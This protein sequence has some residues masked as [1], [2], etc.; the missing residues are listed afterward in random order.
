M[1]YEAEKQVQ[2]A[3]RSL[4]WYLFLLPGSLYFFLLLFMGTRAFEQGTINARDTWVLIKLGFAV[5]CVRQFFRFIIFR[6]ARNVRRALDDRITV[7]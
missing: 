2:K 7:R 1:T 4:P 5:W 3:V 6:F